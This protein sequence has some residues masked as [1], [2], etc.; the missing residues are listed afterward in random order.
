MEHL[1]DWEVLLAER[2]PACSRAAGRPIRST[3]SIMDLGGVTLSRFNTARGVVM[4]LMQARRGAPARNC[5]QR[6][7]AT[8]LRELPRLC[9]L[10]LRQLRVCSMRS[11]SV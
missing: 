7:T 4:T 9:G 2:F 3:L 5:P 1:L 10:H 6:Q 8:Q 11:N